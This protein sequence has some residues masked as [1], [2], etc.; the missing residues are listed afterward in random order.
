MVFCPEVIARMCRNSE[1]FRLHVYQHDLRVEDI[2][3]G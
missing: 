2:R 1:A 3:G